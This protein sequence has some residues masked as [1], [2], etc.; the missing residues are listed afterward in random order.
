M[1]KPIRVP[2]PKIAHV[3]VTPVGGGFKVQHMM[4]PAPAKTFV[5]ADPK[6][7]MQHL[8]KIQSSQWR[9]PGRNE[10]IPITHDLDLGPTS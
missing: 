1:P 10:A 3:S 5:F 8:N 6:K 2:T 4:H 7:M 9:E